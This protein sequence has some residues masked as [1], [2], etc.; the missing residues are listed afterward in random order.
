MTAELSIAEKLW[1][2]VQLVVG[3]GRIKTGND[4][5]LVQMQQVQ[6]G[7]AEIRDNTPRVSE[8]GFTSMPLPG[9]HGIVIFVGGDRSNGV[10]IATNDQ[11]HRLKNLQ[12]GEVAIYDDQGQS[13]YL[14]RG[15]ID[16]NGAGLPITVHNT[17]TVRVTADTSVTLDTP[18]VHATQNMTVDGLLTVGNFK[19]LAGGTATWAGGNM[20]Y[21]GMTVT[22]TGSSI[23]SNGHSID[24]TLQVTG[25]T[26]G[27]GTSGNPV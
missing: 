5:G 8:Y 3:R 6:L 10:M 22:Y 2:R 19:M 18:L 16:V 14:K 9:C 12:P 1:R 7:A 20:A 4:A 23:K 11:N 27:G 21:S 15:G 24:H 25:V 17:P 13:V 26:P